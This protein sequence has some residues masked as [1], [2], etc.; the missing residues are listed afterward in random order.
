M[1]VAEGDQLNAESPEATE[2]HRERERERER[3]DNLTG[4]QRASRLGWWTGR[5]AGC[6][7]RPE[8]MGMKARL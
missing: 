6:V 7:R 8:A 4:G 3:V 5:H 2:L 1:N